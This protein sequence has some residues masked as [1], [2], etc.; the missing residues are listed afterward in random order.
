M[1][2]PPGCGK[3]TWLG[4]QVERAVEREKSVLIASLTK[5]A[6][7]EVTA[8]ALPVPQESVGTLHAHCYRGLGKPALAQSKEALE[9]WNR[10]YPCY[11]MTPRN[12]GPSWSPYRD[13]SHPN[14]SRP[15]RGDILMS[16]YEA[17][18]YTLTLHQMSGPVAMFASRW[19]KWKRENGLLDFTDLI[20][21]ALRDLPQAPGNPDVIFI[22]EVQDLGKLEL[23]LIRRWGRKAG[24]LILVG[25][26]DQSI[27]TWR[28][29]DPQ[30]FT[31]PDLPPDQKLILSTSYRVPVQVHDLAVRWINRVVGRDPVDYEPR[32]AEGA[33]RRVR[34]TWKVPDHAIADAVEQ[35]EQGRTTMFIASCSYMLGPLI[36]ALRKRGIPFSNR[37]RP[38]DNCW[39]PLRNVGDDNSVAGQVLDFLQLR[40]KGSYASKDI[41]RLTRLLG[42]N[43]ASLGLN[44]GSGN[45][46]LRWLRR[47]IRPAKRKA[48]E[49]PIAVVE[50]GGIEALQEPPR[51]TVGTIHSVKGGEADVVYVFPDLSASAMKEWNRGAT[52]AVIYRLFYVAITRAREEVVIC[53]P[54]G[55]SAVILR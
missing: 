19:E 9:D 27:F 35:M 48:A 31:T 33:V 30:G 34:A 51:A 2:G 20:E 38:D 46:D 3:T 26:C 40:H 7:E 21:T 23:D 12:A 22:D 15:Q 54:A 43:I 17:H 55:K 13:P 32:P 11:R 44:F 36:T 8:R 41:E 24:Y 5:A 29:A 28:G 18:R 14:S 25:D 50:R 52:R 45:G 10:L 6:A 1:I 37:Y 4:R 53:A 42:P 47:H 39:N 49:Y 16:R